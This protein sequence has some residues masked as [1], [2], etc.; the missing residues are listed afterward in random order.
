ML[1]NM[2]KTCDKTKI[3]ARHTCNPNLPKRKS[4]DPGQLELHGKTLSQK[5]KKKITRKG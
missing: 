5:K 2:G 4:Y 1:A 3:T